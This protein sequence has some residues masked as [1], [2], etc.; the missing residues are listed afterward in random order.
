MDFTDDTIRIDQLRNLVGQWKKVMVP[1]WTV[2]LTGPNTAHLDFNFVPNWIGYNTIEERKQLPVAFENFIV[3]F[4][5]LVGKL[6]AEDTRKE[7]T[8][9][10]DFHKLQEEK[11]MEK[12]TYFFR[13]CRSTRRCIQIV[14]TKGGKYELYAYNG[15]GLYK[16]H[17]DWTSLVIRSRSMAFRARV[18]ACLTTNSFPR[19]VA[20]GSS[21]VNAIPE[22]CLTKF[23]D[24]RRAL[25]DAL[26]KLDK[27]RENLETE[28]VTA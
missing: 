17:P 26:N 25:E 12:F 7:Y 10:V 3:S 4:C 20:T 6:V 11:P 15:M 8:R 28:N 21:I 23:S 9:R 1:S 19:T 22:G 16:S 13:H 2:L 5:T 18:L 14:P 24:V 27:S